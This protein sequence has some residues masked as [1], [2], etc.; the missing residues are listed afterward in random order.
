MRH[1]PPVTMLVQVLP[2][3]VVGAVLGATDGQMLPPTDWTDMVKTLG[4]PIFVAVYVL[5]LLHSTVKENT[6]AVGELTGKLDRL[7]DRLGQ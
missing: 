5:W 1:G 3:L 4:F 6:K 7:L 2:V